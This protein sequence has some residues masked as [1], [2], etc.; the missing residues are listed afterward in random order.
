MNYGL[1]PGMDGYTDTDGIDSKRW[2]TGRRWREPLSGNPNKARNLEVEED[3]QIM[4]S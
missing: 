3:E 2:L 1:S 4:W